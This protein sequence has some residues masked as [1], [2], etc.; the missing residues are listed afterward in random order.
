MCVWGLHKKLGRVD[1][2]VL[3]LILL[4]I[5][6]QHAKRRPYRQRVAADNSATPILKTKQGSSRAVI[7]CNVSLL[8]YDT[9]TL[10]KQN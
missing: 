6:Q 2:Q 4:V 9:S 5:V 8:L 7:D 1:V 10:E 3:I